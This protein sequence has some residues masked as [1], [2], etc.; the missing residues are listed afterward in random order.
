MNKLP[1]NAHI[2]TLVVLTVCSATMIGVI[3]EALCYFYKIPD[4]NSN[5]SHGFTHTVD[6]L[7]GA[8][9]AMLITTRSQEQR[10]PDDEILPSNTT[11]PVT[12]ENKP[13]DPIPVTAKSEVKPEPE[14]KT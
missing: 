11:I 4:M 12:V 7:V 8:L 14:S 3:T 6:T 9:L 13:S 1:N 2:I 5:L 10:L